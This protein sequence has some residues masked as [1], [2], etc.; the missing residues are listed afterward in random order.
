M[1]TTHKLCNGCWTDTMR[2]CTSIWK[3]KGQCLAKPFCPVAI[4]SG[5]RTH[6]IFYLQW[7]LVHQANDML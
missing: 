6:L 2:E 1:Q 5:L 7:S 4:L 3:Q